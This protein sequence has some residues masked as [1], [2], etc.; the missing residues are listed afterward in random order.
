M[1]QMSTVFS[2][3]FVLK[4][5]AKNMLRI[6]KPPKADRSLLWDIQMCT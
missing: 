2:K 5:I 4:D 3:K 6:S 1:S